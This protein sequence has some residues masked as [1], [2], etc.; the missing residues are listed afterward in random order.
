MKGEEVKSRENGISFQKKWVN[1]G[2]NRFPDN[3]RYLSAIELKMADIGQVLAPK[4][5]SFG[6]YLETVE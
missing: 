4:A 3:R 1:S 2:E 5:I 6:C